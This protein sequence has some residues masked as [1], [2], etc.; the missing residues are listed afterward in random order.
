MTDV[1]IPAG[2]DVFSWEPRFTYHGFRFVEITGPEIQA[3]AEKLRSARSV[4]DDMKTIGP[5]RDFR[6]RRSIRCSRMPTGAFAAI[7]AACRPTVRS[8]TSAWAGS[9]TARR[10]A[11]AR[12]SC[13]VRRCFTR[14]G[15]RDIRSDSQRQRR[16]ACP[17][18]RRPTGPFDQ[19]SGNVTWPA[20]Y[21]CVAD[22]LY[23]QYGD[24]VAARRAPLCRR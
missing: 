18:C 3:R 5:F 17:T 14:S 10:A 4:Y 9:A 12:A 21:L 11:S 24:E 2:D 16:A 23:N 7:T 15:L 22:M 19:H 8:A 20:A 1:Y 13:S 6:S